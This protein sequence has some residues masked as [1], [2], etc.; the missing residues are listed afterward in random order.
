[1]KEAGKKVYFQKL[2]SINLGLDSMHI[3]IKM[4]INQCIL[5]PF[6]HNIL[7]QGR[8]VHVS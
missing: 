4:M 2:E 7:L 3:C 6:L 1:M 5:R 8:K